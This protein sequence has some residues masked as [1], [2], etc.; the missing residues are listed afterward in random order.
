[1]DYSA[2]SFNKGD[3]CIVSVPSYGGRVPAPAVS[4]LRL[5]R[6]N[7]AGAI[8]I[9]TYGNRDYDDTFAELKDVLEEAG[10]VCLAAV[11]A[12][13]QHSKIL[14]RLRDLCEKMSRWRNPAGSPV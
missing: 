11:A 5:T 6:G 8:L 9:G 3:V 12:V 14:H 2:F 1:M 4:R 7:G 13:T 10:Y